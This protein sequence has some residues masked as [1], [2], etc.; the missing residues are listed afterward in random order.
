MGKEKTVVA[1]LSL[2]R[3]RKIQV[4]RRGSGWGVVPDAEWGKRKKEVGEREER[5]GPD[6]WAPASVVLS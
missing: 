4:F 1:S 5:S 2:N 6:Q 3:R